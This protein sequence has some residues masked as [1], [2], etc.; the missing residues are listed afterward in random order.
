MEVS[1]LIGKLITLKAMHG[2]IRVLVN[3]SEMQNPVFVAEEEGCPAYISVES[4]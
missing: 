1:E 4:E 3:H 2:N